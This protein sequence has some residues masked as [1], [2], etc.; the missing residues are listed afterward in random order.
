[1]ASCTRPEHDITFFIDDNEFRRRQYR[2][3]VVSVI[4]CPRCQSCQ[5]PIQHPR[6][7]VAETVTEYLLSQ[8][9]SQCPSQRSSEW[10]FVS[11]GESEVRQR[12]GDCSR[13]PAPTPQTERQSGECVYRSK[14]GRR[15]H[16]RTSC[17]ALRRTDRT[18]LSAAANL[19]AVTVLTQNSWSTSVQKP[20]ARSL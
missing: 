14:A 15:W 2:G 7:C 4:L 11:D 17:K 12:H 9:P 6:R 18:A 5:C 10:N 1:M 19:K 16:K 3:T 13:P 20:R 8:C